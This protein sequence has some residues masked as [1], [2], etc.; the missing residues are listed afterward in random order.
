MIK[1]PQIPSYIF[2]KKYYSHFL[3]TEFDVVFNNS[4]YE[5]MVLLI[6]SIST[7]EIEFYSEEKKY[8]IN[9]SNPTIFDFII[10]YD[11]CFENDV[12]LYYTNHYIKDKESK[13]ELYVSVENELSIFACEKEILYTFSLIFEP[14]KNET[15]DTKYKVITDMFSDKECKQNFIDSLENNYHF[16]DSENFSNTLENC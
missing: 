14:Y 6:T 11:D 3:Y 4:F 12:P 15:L 7:K 13:W 10:F 16:K 2:N 1:K 9:I 5:K 8:K